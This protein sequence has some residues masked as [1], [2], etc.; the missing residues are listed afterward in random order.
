MEKNSLNLDLTD[1]AELKAQLQGYE[2]GDKVTLEITV[3]VKS[4]DDTSFEASVEE[5]TEAPEAP[6]DE[7]SEDEGEG[8]EDMGE[9]A[10]ALVVMI[11]KGKGKP[12]GKPAG[13]GE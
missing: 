8:E 12:M 7:M 3:Q 10:P 11:G 4:V 5:V 9:K 13:K 6:E 2:P 1:N